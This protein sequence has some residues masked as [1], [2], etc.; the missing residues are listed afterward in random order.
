MLR[1]IES[2]KGA[3]WD[4]IVRSFPNWDVYYLCGYARSLEAHEKGRAFLIDFSSGME[5][6]C[7]PV[8][9][10][11]VADSPEFQGLLPGNTW[12]DWETPYGYGGP[13][14]EGNL[15][16]TAQ[17]AFLE[18]LTAVCRERRVVTQFLRFHPLLQNQAVL[19][20]AV[21]YK[22]FKDTVF[23]DL[24]DEE[25]LFQRLNPYHRNR[26]RKARKSGLTIFADHGEH[27]ADFMDIYR[28]TMDRVHAEPY[29]YFDLEYYNRLREALDEAIVFFYA[30]R[31]GQIVAATIFF[32]NSSFIHYHLSGTRTE[33]LK[34]APTNLLIYEA[35]CWAARRG[36]KRL[37]LGG[38]NGG[39]DSLF[40][41]KKK[42]NPAGQLPFYIGR[43]IFDHDAY[44]ELLRLRQTADFR[45]KPSGSFYI[46]Y[47]APKKEADMKSTYIIAEAGVNHNG[48]F[49]VAMKLVDAAKDAGADCVK[50]QTF[51]TEEEIS[52]LAAKADYQKETTD[53]DE[54]QF[55][56]VK[57]LELSF[58]QFRQLK[59]YCDKKDIRF[60]STPFDLLSVRFLD[61]VDMPF[62]K[63]PSGE[64]T[65][66]PYLLAIA[67]TKK[68]VVMSTGMCEMEEIQAAIN[69]LKANGTPR[70]TL[71]HC[72]TEYPTPYEDVNLRAMETM[73]ERFGVEVG[74]SDHTPG[75]EVSIAAAAIGAVIIEKHFTLDRNMEGPD[76]KAS[77]EPGELAAMV[78]GIRRIEKALGSEEKTA[79]PSERKNREI[80]RKSIIARRAIKKG[81]TLTEENL[82]TK[83]PGDGVSPMRWFEVLG[84]SAVRDFEEDERI[85]L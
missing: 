72:N 60:L 79:S 29:Y 38:G 24:S 74:Y 8:I 44:Q 65:N 26:V 28:E 61:T 32:Y 7:Y 59:D 27:L 68:P 31:E 33:F 78:N 57:N 69:I 1:L 39:N 53:A 85:E 40:E 17:R 20:S 30:V 2:D 56:M 34:L 14:A 25:K 71:L 54:T 4:S 13:L 66:L 41:F 76:H 73:R 81:E 35:A 12:F 48:S 5:R 22:T 15:S 80:A 50:F 62:W 64:V 21:Q 43:T 16:E 75:I 82:T 49:E 19:G 37:H 45:F 9:E 84:T 18:E 55:D 10:K 63:I 52:K 51:V 58:E 47:K 11:D 6:L 70:I 46:Q 77:L 36:I 67:K 23:M 83:R 42:F 3:L